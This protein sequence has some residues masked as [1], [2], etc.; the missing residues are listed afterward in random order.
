MAVSSVPTRIGCPAAAARAEPSREALLHRLDDLD[1]REAARDVQLGGVADLGV[2][3][4][5]GREV[6]GALGGDPRRARR[7]S[8]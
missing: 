2:D 3:D 4:A 7:G 8:A 6:L 5:V 1:E